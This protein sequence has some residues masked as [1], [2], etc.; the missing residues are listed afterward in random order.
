M[1]KSILFGIDGSLFG[2]TACAYSID[3]AL[4]LDAQL[5][6]VHVVDSRMMDFPL[7]A[8]QAGVLAWNAG[9]TCGLQEALRKRGE[10]CL[11]RAAARAAEAGVPLVSSLEFGHPAQVLAEVQTRTELLVVGRQGEH[12]KN[13][14][15]LTGSTMERLIRRACRPC[16][17]TP[18]AF[19]RIDKILLGVDGS[20]AGGRALSETVE[21]ANALRVPLVILAVAERENDVSEARK[22]ADDAHRLARAHDCAAA[23]IVAV[24]P[25]AN[26]ILEKTAEMECSLVALGSHGHG[27]IYDRLIGA[28]A[29]HVVSR[30]DVPVLL[31][32]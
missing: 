8:P 30:A 12:A 14:P 29:A 16:L 25:P 21:L 18:A 2:E 1:I 10:E 6:A 5:E 9:A 13:A 17:V 4:R 28:A 7:T 23:S 20:P 3:L 19:R 32:R 15:E 24:G 26:V 27:R 22:I 11:G 31:V